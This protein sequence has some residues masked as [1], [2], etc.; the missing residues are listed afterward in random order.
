MSNFRNMMYIICAKR[1]IERE[2]SSV[3]SMWV[4]SQVRMNWLGRETRIQIIR[5][6]QSGGSP[7]DQLA[8]I[9]TFHDVRICNKP[10]FNF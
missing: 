1:M 5:F 4:I 6:M 7:S 3:G 2:F 9:E 8:A 10:T